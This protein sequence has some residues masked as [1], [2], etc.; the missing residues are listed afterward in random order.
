[1]IYSRRVGICISAMAFTYVSILSIGVPANAASISCPKLISGARK[2]SETPK[3]VIYT[4]KG[5]ATVTGASDTCR[6][7][8]SRRITGYPKTRVSWKPSRIA[9]R[10]QSSAPDLPVPPKPRVSKPPDKP[11][12]NNRKDQTKMSF[13]GPLVPPCDVELRDVWKKKLYE[14]GNAS[15]YLGGIF[16]IDNK[17]DVITDNVG[18]VFQR[19]GRPDLKAY[20]KPL[21]EHLRISAVKS[22]RAL[23]RVCFFHNL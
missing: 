19:S 6:E 8:S 7:R 20:H 15:Y 9:P 18:F 10:V 23:N 11:F 22:F 4:W 5:P 13:G 12:G 1:M 16:T 3:V 2:S 14:I 17:S 21:S